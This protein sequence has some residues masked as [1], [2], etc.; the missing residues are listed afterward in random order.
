M[1]DLEAAGESGA[2][3]VVTVRG[4]R[5]DDAQALWEV[6]TCPGVIRGTMQLPF[7]SPD[8]VERRWSGA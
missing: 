1:G 6:F 5:R 3:D 7:Q 2:S 8:E 4:A